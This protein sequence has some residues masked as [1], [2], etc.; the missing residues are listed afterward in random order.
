MKHLKLFEEKN[1]TIWTVVHI[2]S[3]SPF[4][5]HSIFIFDD[6]E[7]AKDYYIFYVNEQRKY[8]ST[9]EDM[10]NDILT[11]EEADEWVENDSYQFIEYTTLTSEGKFE[12]PEEMKKKLEERK[13]NL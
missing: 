11:E 7:S 1:N 5:N 10:N 2:D 4:D 12:L 13:F 8:R 9:R 3:D 6:R